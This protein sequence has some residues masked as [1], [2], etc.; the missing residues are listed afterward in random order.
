MVS[1]ARWPS[2]HPGAFRP[3][4]QPLAVTLVNMSPTGTPPGQP[5]DDPS[6][7]FESARLVS[8]L[9]FVVSAPLRH[10]KVA[11]A[12]FL[13]VFAVGVLAR[14]V[15]PIKW[16]VSGAILAQR[17]P[18]M[19]VL[20]NPTMN[21]EWDAPTRAAREQL[22]RRENLIELCTQTGFV[23]KYL[24]SRAPAVKARDWVFEKLGRH[25]TRDQLLD[26]LADT[27]NERLVVWVGPEGLV[28]ISFT[29]SDREIAFE[30]VQAAVQNFIE[31]RYATEVRMVGE[32][33]AILEGRDAE[34][35][36]QITTIVDQLEQKERALRIRNAPAR[37]APRPRVAPD[38][39]LTR[40]ENTL[41]ARRRA[42]AALEEFR[43][44][45][46]VELQSQLQQQLGIYA[47]QHPTVQSTRRAI[48][49]ASGP[50]A[51]LDALHAEIA[52][53]ERELQRRGGHVDAFAAAGGGGLD[54]LAAAARMRLESDDPRLEYERRQL[55]MLLR[56]HQQFTERLDAARVELDTAQAAFK[57]RYIV[58]TPPQLPRAPAKPYGLLFLGGG[59]AGGIAFALFL[60]ASLDVLSGRI[61]ERWQI[62]QQ[63]GLT[64]FTDLRW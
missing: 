16:T 23:D 20:S 12:A 53:L 50:S 7:V 34:V 17:S 2:A 10:K 63:L 59:L 47:A 58:V 41:G 30:M 13:A 35:Q 33:I 18:V 56:Q 46:L 48:E 24:A 22:L 44:Q 57:Y 11:V 52:G 43:Q 42:A 51:Q 28:N 9:R 37:P 14:F 1:S 21:R 36:K 8:W 3:G 19:G 60:S 38:E 55:D 32:T 5:Q 62:E 49:N 54:D 64:V 4:E 40:L 25:R 27:L 26:A 61:I 45:R 15:V 39:E 6:D 29:W 31:G